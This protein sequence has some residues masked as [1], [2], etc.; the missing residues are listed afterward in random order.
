MQ[1]QIMRKHPYIPHDSR[2]AFHYLP[3]IRLFVLEIT[4][5]SIFLIDRFFSDNHPTHTLP[6]MGNRVSR[7]LKMPKSRQLELSRY[8]ISDNVNSPE[9]SVNVHLID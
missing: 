5:I 1:H 6:F 9:N 2:F 8:T 3:C 4:S 7:S